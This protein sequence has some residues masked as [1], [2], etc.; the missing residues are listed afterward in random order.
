VARLG[1][2]S[3]FLTERALRPTAGAITAAQQWA[4]KRRKSLHGL[5]TRKSFDG[6]VSGEM[7]L[8][9]F[10][11]GLNALFLHVR[12]NVSFSIV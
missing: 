10:A 9:D 12:M 11:H 3:A 8:Y 2:K 1:C 4:L 6:T 5:S 7:E